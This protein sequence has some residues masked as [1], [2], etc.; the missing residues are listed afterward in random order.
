[1]F[2]NGAVDPGQHV[3]DGLCIACMGSSLLEPCDVQISC[4]L[5]H[6]DKCTSQQS[7]PGAKPSCKGDDLSTGC[8]IDAIRLATQQQGAVDTCS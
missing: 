1:M 6:A 4:K 5:A 3:S 8:T 7:N 2:A